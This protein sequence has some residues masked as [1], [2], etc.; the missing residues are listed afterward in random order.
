[1][2]NI[3]YIGANELVFNVDKGAGIFS[4]GF[5]INSVMMK[6]GM[7]PIMTINGQMG[8][9]LMGGNLMG[10]DTNKVSDLF[11]NL[12]IPAWAISY[13][14]SS[15]NND[16]IGGRNKIKDDDSDSDC[17]SDIDDDLHDKL[18]DLVKDHDRKLKEIK[19]RKT[20]KQGL[21][22]PKKS[23]KKNR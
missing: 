2:S 22:A 17:D 9:N 21:N 12:A 8:G 18:L 3:D 15:N 23:T 20:R 16:M 11:N 7:S 10:G 5:N 6:A 19:K 14:N 4:G 1:M 13:N